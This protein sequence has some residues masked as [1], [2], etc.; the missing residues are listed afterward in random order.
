[1]DHFLDIYFYK[2]TEK[3]VP[4]TVQQWR[5][6]L[7]SQLNM[8]LGIDGHPGYWG[9]YGASGMRAC[10]GLIH[11]NIF[12]KSILASHWQ[13]LTRGKLFASTTRCILRIAPWVSKLLWLFRSSGESRPLKASRGNL[14]GTQA[15]AV[16]LG[17]FEG[18]MVFL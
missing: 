14:R 9:L 4:R 5:S 3:S 12:L 18:L 11:Q 6:W 13:L 17:S 2:P 7:T 16:T 1:M 8:F 15:M 10:L